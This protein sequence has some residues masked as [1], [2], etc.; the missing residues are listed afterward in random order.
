MNKRPNSSNYKKYLC[1]YQFEGKQWLI[2][3]HARSWDEAEARLKTVR[4]G[5]VIGEIDG[6]VPVSIGWLA[7]LIVWWKNHT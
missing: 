2:D 4:N 3:I 5:K 6:E 7:K 1:Q